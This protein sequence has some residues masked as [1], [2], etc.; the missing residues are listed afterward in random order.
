MCHQQLVG[1]TPGQTSSI[2]YTMTQLILR[3]INSLWVQLQARPAPFT[4]QWHSLYCV[5]STACGFNYWPDQLH[6]VH[7][8]TAY[9]TCHQQL[10]GS[11]PGQTSSI[12]YT[13]TQLILRVIN[14]LW[15][16]LQARPAPF[17]TQWHSL[18]CV[19]STACGFNSW[20]DQLHSLHNDTAYTACHQQ[21]VGS[22]PDQ[23]SSVHYA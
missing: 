18:Y 2:H 17:T 10:V 16:Q 23:S 22:T 8:D 19:S 11:T 20:P 3:V 5:S 13:M 4:T 1:S 6:S 12:Q 15:V 9:T 21:L 7:N 14:S